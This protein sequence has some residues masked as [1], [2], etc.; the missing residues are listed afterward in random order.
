MSLNVG[1]FHSDDF[2]GTNE[3][4][5]SVCEPNKLPQMVVVQVYSAKSEFFN[6][7]LY[8]FAIFPLLELLDVF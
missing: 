7:C 2:L 3:L 1:N 4:H 5:E 6:E 8:E